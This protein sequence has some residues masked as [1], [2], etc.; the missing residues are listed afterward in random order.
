MRH[1]YIAI[2]A[3]GLAVLLGAL[4]TYVVVS[5]IS[6]LMNSVQIPLNQVQKVTPIVSGY[7]LGYIAAMPLLGQSSDRFGRR[8][9]LQLCLAGF[10]VGSILTA[11]AGSDWNPLT[12]WFGGYFVLVAGRVLQG[13]ASGALLPVTLALAADLWDQRN[14]ATVLGWVGA[15]QELGSVLGPLYG[16]LCL[17]L[18]GSLGPDA[19]R[20]IFWVNV[21]LAALAMAL[22]QYSVPDHPEHEGPR[23]KVDV[24]GGLLL[25]VALGLVV[26][27]LYNPNLGAS[28][29]DSGQQQPPL[30]PWGV[31]LLIG[32]AAALLAFLLW[33]RRARTTLIERTGVRWTPFLTSLL[34]SF[35]AGAALMVTLVNV[36]L[37]GRS[38]LG[39]SNTD[40]TFLLSWFLIALPIGAV[41]GG[42][43]AS[44]WDRRTRGQGGE[45]V[46]AV[47]GM[48]VAAFGYWLFSRWPEDVLHAT[49]DLGLVALPVL[50]TDLVVAGFGLG[51]V[52]APLSAAALRAVPV[53]SHGVASSGVVV[54][55]MTGMLIGVSGL[56]AWGLYRLHALYAV[57]VKQAP[58]LPADAPFADRVAQSAHFLITAYHLEYAEIFELTALICVFGAIAAAF[59]GGPRT[60]G[61]LLEST[62]S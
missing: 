35:A 44:F 32:A 28:Q 55:R 46:V 40:A 5:I 37:Y 3:G 51:L 22:V 14:R 36:E 29:G 15:A 11:T 27:G 19:W 16:I 47:V 42:F 52:I 7:L 30:S 49:H 58:P 6:E 24:V 62:S 48:V 41:G 57:A 60:Q 8:H 61:D 20:G 59:V 50:H 56:T 33:E 45:R 17:W 9:V 21:P 10:I 13:T 38:V 25:A 43:V 4:D 39:L 53:S 31:P 23:A 18:F 1:R 12:D 2:A 26:V 54:A 34:S